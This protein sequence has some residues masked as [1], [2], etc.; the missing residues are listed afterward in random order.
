MIHTSPNSSR[1]LYAVALQLLVWA[2]CS[3]QESECKQRAE[4]MVI[5]FYFLIH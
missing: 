2:M 5:S 3:V 1:K 4:E